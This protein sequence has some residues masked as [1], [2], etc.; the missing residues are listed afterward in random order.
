[1]SRHSNPNKPLT[2]EQVAAAA[3]VSTMTVSRVLRGTDNVAAKTREKVNAC[4]E[5]LGYVHNKIAGALA[6]SSGTQ[7]AVIV[8]SLDSIVFTELLSG[9]AAGLNASVYQ[10]VI[11]ISE[12]DLD[13][14][15]NIV[16]TMLGWRP[17]AFILA[18]TRHLPKTRQLLQA[19][20][21]P[22]VEV[23]ELTRNPID[24]CVGLNQRRAGK[25]MAAHLLKKNYKR[26]AYLGSDHTVDRAAALR[27]SGFQSELQRNGIDFEHRLTVAGHSGITLGRQYMPQL[28]HTCKEAEVVYFSNDAVAAGAMMHCLA[29]GINI[30]RD[31]ALASFSGLEIAS[32]MPV[33]IT[34][35]R[36]PRF[37]MGKLSAQR[38]LASLQGETVKRITDTDFTLIEGASA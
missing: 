13:R 23:M 28:L 16:R 1:M 33:P 32:A 25:V 9:I 31:I 20:G 8:P 22:V 24:I 27:C 11:G 17:A 29:N 19:W 38:L 34:T 12:Y 21:A 37:E 15:L 10:Q 26:F 6:A 4:M 36:S 30:P 5:E 7:I 35:I 18:S 3:G 14:E 2:I